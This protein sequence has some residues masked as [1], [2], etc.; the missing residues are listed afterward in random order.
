MTR[1]FWMEAGVARSMP[2]VKLKSVVDFTQYL[3]RKAKEGEPIM[4]I[5]S[6]TENYDM[7]GELGV[8]E[9]VDGKTPDGEEYSWLK[10]RPPT[11]KPDTEEHW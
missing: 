9:I 8:D 6:A 5:A 1:V 4:F 3:R 11:I 2:M 10:R 7:V